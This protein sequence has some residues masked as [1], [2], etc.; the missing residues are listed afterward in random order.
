MAHQCPQ[1]SKQQL[2]CSFM[3]VT[4]TAVQRKFCVIESNVIPRSLE[5]LQKK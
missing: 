3:D 2:C 5:L 4:C 1:N